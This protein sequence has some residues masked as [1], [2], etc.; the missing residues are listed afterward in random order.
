MLLVIITSIRSPDRAS[1]VGPGN[2]PACQLAT[3][4]RTTVRSRESR[5]VDEVDVLE[6]AIRPACPLGNVPVQVNCA[7][8]AEY[9]PLRMQDGWVVVV[10]VVAEFSVALRLCDLGATAVAT[11][12]EPSAWR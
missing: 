9:V 11:I 7:W 10:E 2:W 12:G 5:T 8:L 1:I 3:R 4:S 6:H